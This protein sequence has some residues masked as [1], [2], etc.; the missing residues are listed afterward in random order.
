[1][2]P[3]I[4]AGQ[5]ELVSSDHMLGDYVSLIPTPGHTPGHVSV[6]INDAGHEAVISGDVLHSTIQ[7]LLPEWNFAYDLDQGLAMETRHAFLAA[8]G[9]VGQLV[10]GS[11]FPLPSLGRVQKVGAAFRWIES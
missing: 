8:A 1:V 10:L 9:E 3:V 11:H 5:A 6:R 4:A 7:C 2:L